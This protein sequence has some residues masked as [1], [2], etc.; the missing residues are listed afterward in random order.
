MDQSKSIK[1]RNVLI[2]ILF[3]GLLTGFVSAWFRG[4]SSS[5]FLTI[6]LGVI[7]YV[8]IYTWFV[9]DR[10]DR[11]LRQHRREYTIVQILM[12]FFMGIGFPWY[13]LRSR[14]VQELPITLLKLIAFIL[15]YFVAAFLGAGFA[16]LILRYVQP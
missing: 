9:F 11:N 8:L 10:V 1:K 13:L 12:V 5:G 14:P 6:G 2:G 15:L 16:L 3:V 7:N 4:K